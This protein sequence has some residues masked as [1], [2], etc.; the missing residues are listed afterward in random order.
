MKNILQHKNE[1]LELEENEVKVLMNDGFIK[2]NGTVSETNFY[3][4]CSPYGWEDVNMI[5][6]ALAGEVDD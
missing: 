6:I 4:I 1:T 3:H 2:S 5:L